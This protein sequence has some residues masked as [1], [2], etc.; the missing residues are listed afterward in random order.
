MEETTKGA[1][2]KD[3]PLKTL[4]NLKHVTNIFHV[5]LKATQNIWMAIFSNNAPQMNSLDACEEKWISCVTCVGHTNLIFKAEIR[6]RTNLMTRMKC[7]GCECMVFRAD[8][9]FTA[10]QLGLGFSSNQA[11]L[12]KRVEKNYYLHLTMHTLKKTKKGH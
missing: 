8:I 3:F 5:N 4:N 6:L 7:D 2:K 11:P 12:A 10:V 9:P 1:V